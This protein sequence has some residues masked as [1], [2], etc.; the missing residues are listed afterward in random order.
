M[1]FVSR[2]PR[3]WGTGADVAPP[4]TGLRR[5][6]K[7][8]KVS[9]VNN[10]IMLTRLGVGLAGTLAAA[11][12]AACS[13]TGGAT[14]PTPTATQ[15]EA[16]LSATLGTCGIRYDDGA[17]LGDGGQSL[18]LD[19]RGEEDFDGLTYDS[20]KCVLEDLDVPDATMNLIETT[21]ALDG[22]QTGSWDGIDATWSYHPDN[23][24][25][26]T[27]VDSNHES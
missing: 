23:G 13:S 14:N 2:G 25:N 18:T 26:V 5:M 8:P 21:R 4:L 7:G 9:R 6:T 12:L 1:P 19:S 17:Q 27:L 11:A 20:V 24:V 22:R 16:R 10:R 3:G 15:V